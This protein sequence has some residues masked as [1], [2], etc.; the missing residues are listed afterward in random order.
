MDQNSHYRVP[1]G[2]ERD[3]GPMK[4]SEE[5]IAKNIP[6]MRREHSRH[7]RADSLIQDKPKE[8][9]TKTHINQT[10]KIKNRE[11]IL[12]AIREK[13]QITYKII[14]IRFQQKLCRPEGSGMIYL[15]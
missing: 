8:E 2:E 5:I 9:Y 1:E 14:P 4:I 12:K 6:N 3:K 13:E 11:K 15:K 10:D 7:K